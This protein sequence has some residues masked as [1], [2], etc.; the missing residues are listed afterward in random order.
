MLRTRR[1]QDVVVGDIVQRITVVQIHR[2]D[3]AREKRILEGLSE[4]LEGGVDRTLLYQRI[5]LETNLLP[6]IIVADRRVTDALRARTRN[7]VPACTP[8]AL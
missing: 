2:T 7:L 8:V 1:H 4:Q 5:H 3:R 6:L